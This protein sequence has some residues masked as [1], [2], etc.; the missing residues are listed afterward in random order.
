MLQHPFSHHLI[1]TLSSALLCVIACSR[2][3]ESPGL[4]TTHGQDAAVQLTGGFHADSGASGSSGSASGST[5]GGAGGAAGSSTG[6]SGGSPPTGGTASIP[7]AAIDA[8]VA[9]PPPPPQ[10]CASDNDCT[11]LGMICD[12][13]ASLC[14]RCFDDLHC[15][16]GFECADSD[17]VP[18]TE[19]QS[20][21]DCAAAP[22]GKTICGNDTGRCVACNINEDCGNPGYC[23]DHQCA[24]A[25]LMNDPNNC[26]A[27]GRVCPYGCVQ[28]DCPLTCD[29]LCPVYAP[30]TTDADCQPELGL[31][32]CDTQFS[33]TCRPACGDSKPCPAGPPGPRASQPRCSPKLRCQLQCSSGVCPEGMACVKEYDY[34]GHVG[35]D[36]CVWPASHFN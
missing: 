4:G 3:G 1:T 35:T 16:A 20:S 5:T 30:C 8:P 17:C 25:D 36:V 21:L 23:I 14:V 32:R 9:P 34:L 26:G 2:S 28:G 24:C 19:C 18:F 10:P 11:P 33:R 27:C 15:P 29:P 6:G 12:P 22:G 7:D 31:M 13:S